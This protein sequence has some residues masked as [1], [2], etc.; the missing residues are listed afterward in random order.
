M[1]DLHS[2]V[3]PVNSGLVQA[4][5]TQGYS[6]EDVTVTIDNKD[7]SVTTKTMQMVSPCTSFY[8]KNCGVEVL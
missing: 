7:K 4:R 5:E 2:L 3:R 1:R 8:Q 6:R